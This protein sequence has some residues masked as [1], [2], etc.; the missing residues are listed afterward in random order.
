MASPFI[1]NREGKKLIEA[2]NNSDMK[3]LLKRAEK[4]HYLS[5]FQK[6]KNKKDFIQNN[7]WTFIKE[8]F[9]DRLNFYVFSFIKEREIFKI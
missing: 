5:Y 1:K 8:E 6:T 3:S 4:I 9:K 7:L 2:T